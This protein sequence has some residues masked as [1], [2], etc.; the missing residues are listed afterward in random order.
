MP[1]PP[2]L[3]V[4][5]CMTTSPL[6]LHF[7]FNLTVLDISEPPKLPSFNEPVTTADD[8]L[9]HDLDDH[10][11]GMSMI[12]SDTNSDNSGSNYYESIF[13]TIIMGA[14]TLDSRMHGYVIIL[15]MHVNV[16]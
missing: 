6:I 5:G 4:H 2:K 1:P 9:S 12:S 11:E 14:W 10:E 8:R 16:I 3:I 15:L 7:T 13:Y